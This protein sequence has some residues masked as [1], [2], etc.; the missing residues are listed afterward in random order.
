MRRLI[1]DVAATLPEFAHLRASRILVV[2]GDARRASHA[3]IRPLSFPVTH[4]RIR[5]DRKREKPLIRIRGRRILYLITLRPLWFRK[6]EPEERVRTLLHELFHISHRFDGTLHSGR[7]HA[8]M[9]VRFYRKLL[10]L[11]QGY[12]QTCRPEIL[13]AFAHNGPVRVAQWLEKPPSSF[14]LG[15]GLRRQRRIYTEEQMFRGSIRMITRRQPG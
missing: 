14:P 1:R 8:R 7:R 13:Q 3:T 15:S 6:L 4:G 9:G 2:A 12:L 5:S 11:V 10:P